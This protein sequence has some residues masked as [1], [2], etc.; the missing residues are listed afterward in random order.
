MSDNKDPEIVVIDPRLPG[1]RRQYSAE[2]K[3]RLVQETEAPG[4]SVSS[5]A[6]RYGLSPSLLFRWRK[7]R[8][9]G[10]LES[11]G[12][13]ERVVPESEV[14]QLKARVRELWRRRLNV[15]RLFAHLARGQRGNPYAVAIGAIQ[16]P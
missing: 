16:N 1:R 15:L 8:D 5:V 13:E 3:Q 11:S 6:R 2:E 12:A 10:S 9:H 7:L 4:E 14:K